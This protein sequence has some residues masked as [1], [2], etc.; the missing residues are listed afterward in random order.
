MLE[1]V[2][3]SSRRAGADRCARGHARSRRWPRWWMC[4]R[5]R[6]SCAGRPISSSR[7]ASQGKPVNIKKGQFLSPWEMQN[8]VD[9]ARSTGNEPIMVCERG[10]SLRLQ[11]PR[12]RH[13]LAVRSC[14]TPTARWC[15]MP[16]IPCSCRAGRAQ[17]PAGSASSSRCWRA[18]PSPPASPECSWRPIPTGQGA[19]R[20]PERLAARPHGSAADGAGRAGRSAVKSRC[21]SLGTI[22]LL[23]KEGPAKP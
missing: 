20:R 14:A 23:S 12:L 9:K 3:S 11:Q 1:D 17:L 13:A 19:L 4:C 10:F 22:S 8:V 7:A 15:S 5:P 21:A 16:P 2:R 18:P 6:P